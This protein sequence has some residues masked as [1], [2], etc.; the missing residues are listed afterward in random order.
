MQIEV[1]IIVP[2]YN[3]PECY[4]RKCI[5]SLREQSLKEI[6]II[7]VDDGS[8]DCAGAICDEYADKDS[9]IR[10]IH[11]ENGGLA[12]ARNT[13]VQA[14]RGKWITMVDGDDWV[15]PYACLEASREGNASGAQVVCCGTIK[16]YGETNVCLNS[17][18]LFE[19]KK[20][21]KDE[22]CRY[23]QQM[24]LRFDSYVCEPNSKL[25]LREYIEQNQIYHNEIL[26]QGMEGIDFC[27]RLFEKTNRVVYLDRHWYHYMY[28]EKSISAQSSEKNN[29]Y[30]IGCLEEIRK[31]IDANSYAS[32]LRPWYFNRI[33]YIVVTT[34]ISGYFHPKNTETFPERC[35]KFSG[36]LEVPVIKEAL[37]KPEYKEMDIQRRI[38]LFLIKNKMFRVL[39]L[40][41]VVRY[42]KKMNE[43]NKAI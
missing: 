42:K 28:N 31:Y 9:R 33:L 3:V 30:I 43:K 18:R 38:I 14:A 41:G 6:E 32:S 10:V 16:N 11:K 1:S 35:K 5:E 26:R 20:I 23:F 7:L 36:F 22:E 12:A 34:A 27:L 24:V 15:E 13:G 21:Y 17:G 19:N 8:T 37:E 2:V 40:M 39:E 25:I 4:L 29:A